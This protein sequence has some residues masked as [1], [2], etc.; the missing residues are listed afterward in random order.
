MVGFVFRISNQ[1]KNDFREAEENGTKIAV[2]ENDGFITGRFATY[3]RYV[4]LM[5]LSCKEV[6]VYAKNSKFENASSSL[7]ELEDLLK[8]V[9]KIYPGNTNTEL[10]NIALQRY[11]EASDC[12]DEAL[13]EA[14]NTQLNL[15]TV[16]AL[17]K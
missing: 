6:R 9:K 13:D 17:R 7:E 12:L 14:Y 11:N 8:G 5:N 4:S 16:K 3:L 10:V 1:M 2:L 15:A